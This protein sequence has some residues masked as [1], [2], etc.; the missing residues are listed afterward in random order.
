MRGG[1]GKV[2][3]RHYFKPDEFKAKCRIC[4]RLTLPP[5]AGIGTHKHETEDEIFLIL[6]G[7]GMMDDGTTKTRVREG[8]AILTGNGASHAITN[9]GRT[10]L[11]I[12][13]VVMCY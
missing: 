1:P 4:A 9:D 5:G 6:K 8:D 3:V 7:E 2:S 12:A 13:A 11:E 10:D